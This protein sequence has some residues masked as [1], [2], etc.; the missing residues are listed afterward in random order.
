[1]SRQ[2]FKFHTFGHID[3]SLRTFI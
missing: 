3:L 2:R 1:M